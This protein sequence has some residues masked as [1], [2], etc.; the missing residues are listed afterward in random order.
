VALT[1]CAHLTKI[2]P[3]DSGRKG[4]LDR[5]ADL[6]GAGLGT[7]P[8]QPLEKASTGDVAFA[9]GRV[10]SW[11]WPLEDVRV[12]SAFGEREHGYHEGID[13]RAAS[14]TP[15]RASAPG[16]VVYA[17]KRI[18]GYGNMVVLKHEGG[19]FTVYAHLSKPLVREGQKIKEGQRV[20]L[21]GSTGRSSGPHLHY[22]IRRGAKPID[23]QEVLP[24][25]PIHG[26]LALFRS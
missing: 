3:V 2:Q 22:E 15:V 9:G 17:G 13:L 10:K 5:L 1:G 25:K 6:Q 26:K 4:L 24:G 21:S 16:Q 19:L 7:R 14:G 23:P 8:S 11:I 18:G 20:A 12:T